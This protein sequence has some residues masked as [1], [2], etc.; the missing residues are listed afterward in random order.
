MFKK[1][2]LQLIISYFGLFPFLIILLDKFFFKFFDYNKVNNF[3]IFYSIII[4]VFIGA[5]NWNLKRNISF[6]L[7]FFGFI[8]SFVSVFII[9][10][11]LY[12]YE[13]IWY[14]ILLLIFQLIFDNF[15][16]K[17]KNDRAIYYQLR[18]PLTLS[19]VLCLILIQL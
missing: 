10:M 2:N 19:I 17:E 13:V 7:I 12:S 11:F 9:I 5:I 8:P 6:I 4:C 15:N 16:Y 14:V 3:S 1:I 18:V